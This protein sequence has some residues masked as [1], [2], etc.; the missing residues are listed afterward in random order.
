MLAAAK[1]GGAPLGLII[2]DI[3]HFKSINDRYGHPFGDRVIQLLGEVLGAS[4]RGDRQLLVQLFSNLIENAIL[5]TPAGT[6]ITLSLAIAADRA[7]VAVSD[8]GPGV[9]PAEHDRLFRRLYR[10]EASRTRPGYGLGLSLVAAIAELHGA[11]ARIAPRDRP[12]LCVEISFP[13]A[14]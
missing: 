1:H 11:K 7:V 14:T 12:G 5:H 2:L 9:P 6:R 10:R 8:D 4:I 3:D 13:L